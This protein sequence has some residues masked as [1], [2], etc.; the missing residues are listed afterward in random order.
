MVAGLLALGAAVSIWRSE[1]P[2]GTAHLYELVAD[3]V[4]SFCRSPSL[5]FTEEQEPGRAYGSF[6][7]CPVCVAAAVRRKRDAA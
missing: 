7:R 4:V 1:T 3:R 5:S 6:K 2:L